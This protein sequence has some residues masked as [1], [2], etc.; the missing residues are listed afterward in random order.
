M[1]YSIRQQT[2][3]EWIVGQTDCSGVCEVVAQCPSAEFAE[4]VKAGLE[5]LEKAATDP[6]TTSQQEDNK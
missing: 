4:K 1:R 6:R 5:A 3:E 2:I